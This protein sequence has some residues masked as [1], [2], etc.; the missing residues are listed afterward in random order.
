MAAEPAMPWAVP[1]SRSYPPGPAVGMV[2]GSLASLTG[3][4]DTLRRS[5]LLAASV[6][7]AAT[8]GLLAVWVFA[9]DNPGTLTEDGS[10]Y[11]FRVP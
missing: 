10:R 7:L 3:E 11:S 4:T 2:E 1:G 8:Y 9:S 5:R 6:F